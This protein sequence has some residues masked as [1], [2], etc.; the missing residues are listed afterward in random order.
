MADVKEVHNLI[1]C[2][3]MKCFLVMLI[4]NP[5][6]I[7]IFRKEPFFYGHDNYDQLVKIAKVCMP[8]EKF[9]ICL[10]YLLYLYLYG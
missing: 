2:Q 1:A 4:L 10:V 5:C 3:E 9:T 7:Q 8:K 6:S